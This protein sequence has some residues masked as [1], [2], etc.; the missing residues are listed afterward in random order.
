MIITVEIKRRK[1]KRERER[2]REHASLF[3]DGW[4]FRLVIDLNLLREEKTL[5]EHF[6]I[7][8]VPLIL[9]PPSTQELRVAHGGVNS[10]RR[11]GIANALFKSTVVIVAKHLLPVLTTALVD[12]S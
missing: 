5:Q 1:K 6:I 12:D 11:L 4:Q 3:E 10:L 8:Y 7:P 2:I 9:Q